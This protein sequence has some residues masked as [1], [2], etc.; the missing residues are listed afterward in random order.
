MI[1]WILKKLFKNFGEAA[2]GIFRSGQPGF[3]RRWIMYRLMKFKSVINLAWNPQDPQDEDELKFCAKRGIPYFPF[4]W[5]AAGPADW[6]EIWYA[7]DIIEHCEKPVWIHCEGGKDRTGGLI[8]FWKVNHNYTMDEIFE[9]FQ[10]YKYPAWQ[11]IKY[12]FCGE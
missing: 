9:D 7:H 6:K 1:K 5:G 2:P 8:A 12:P 10:T 4:K 3:I 11:W